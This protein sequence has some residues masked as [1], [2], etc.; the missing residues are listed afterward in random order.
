MRL[1]F[2]RSDHLEEELLHA[3]TSGHLGMEGRNQKVTLAH[4]GWKAV[5]PGKNFRSLTPARDAR[6]A[7]KAISSGPP[8]NQS[9]RSEWLA[10]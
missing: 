9:P 2:V 1:R 6:R 10:N 8:G 3:G 7:N 4:K 5:A